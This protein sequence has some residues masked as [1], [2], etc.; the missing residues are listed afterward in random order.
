[1]GWDCKLFNY[2]KTPL[3]F[4]R[5]D[6]SGGHR[7]TGIPTATFLFLFCY[8]MLPSSVKRCSV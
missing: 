3:Y 2:L 5:T 8:Q 1:M 4:L 7:M 6:M